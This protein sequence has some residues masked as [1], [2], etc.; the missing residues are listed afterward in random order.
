MNHTSDL[1]RLDLAGP[2]AQL[3]LNRSETRNAL[4]LEMLAAAHQRLDEIDAL[5]SPPMVLTITGAGSSFCA[6]MDLKQVIIEQAGDAET[7]KALLE[8]LARLTHRIR[9]LPCVTLAKVNG[10]AIGGGCG[11]A[12]VCDL[13]ITHADSKMGFPEVDLGLCPA[14]VAPWLV[15]R[16]GPGQ[17][18]RVLLTGGLL[19][20]QQAHDLGIVGALVPTRDHLDQAADEIAA[21]LTR[22]GPKALRATKELLNTL[23]GSLD[24]DVLLKGATLS[25]SVLV[26][27][28][29]QARLK[30][31]RG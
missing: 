11:L 4:S 19:S 12:C 28:D 2:S 21:S 31:R 22:G 25:A 23:D 20:G 1:V 15:R 5:K 27:P 18:R 24:L 16:I 10:A 9:L 29:A 6:G 8:S 30:A 3:T 13:S 26:T 7:P 17:A 14:V